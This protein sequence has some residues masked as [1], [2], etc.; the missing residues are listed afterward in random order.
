[1]V[2]NAQPETVLKFKLCRS[3]F[4]ITKA[5]AEKQFFCEIL[6]CNKFNQSLCFY[7]DGGNFMMMM[8]MMWL[9]IIAIIANLMVGNSAVVKKEINYKIWFRCIGTS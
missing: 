2:L 4:L 5:T 1:M 3:K 9:M 8:M 7:D 6:S